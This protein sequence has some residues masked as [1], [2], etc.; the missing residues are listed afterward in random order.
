MD[1][2]PSS[3]SGFELKKQT[4]YPPVEQQQTG[5]ESVFESVLGLKD[6]PI[7]GQNE[8]TVEVKRAGFKSWFT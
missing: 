8:S 1:W 2:Q 6:G 3:E 4:F 7:F 5:L